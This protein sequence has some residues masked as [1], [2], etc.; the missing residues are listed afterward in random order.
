MRHRY[1]LAVAVI[2]ALLFVVPAGRLS[3]AT[4]SFTPFLNPIGVAYAPGSL[5]VTNYCDP[6][7]IYAIDD[8]GNASL[9]ASLPP[10]GGCVE[11]YMAVS[12]GGLPKWPAN[13]IYAIGATGTIFEID[14]NGSVSTFAQ[15]PACGLTHNALTFDDQGRFGNILIATCSTGEIYTITR[16]G[17]PTLLTTIS[18]FL[19]GPDVAP[20]NF[21][22]HGGD[23]FVSSESS[24]NVYDVTPTGAFS[25][26]A[27]WPAAEG[28][29]FIPTNTC[30]FGGSHASYFRANFGSN[31]ILASPG[32]DFTGLGGLGLVRSEGG[33]FGAGV[34]HPDGT[35]T[36][37]GLDV[38]VDLE[39]ATFVDF[40]PGCR[41]NKP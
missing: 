17:T 34:L 20:L 27:N 28:I 14:P 10:Q 4:T 40:S 37:L 22:T 33:P 19:E 7:G 25:V 39:G 5:L 23:L 1:S 36:P 11:V 8:V 21:G 9:F 3:A 35:I 24:G 16:T 15:L 6:I 31:E 26:F 32:S 18:D 29:N 41:F 2:V 38:G 12:P 13:R 30:Q